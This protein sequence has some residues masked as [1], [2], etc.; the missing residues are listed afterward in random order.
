MAN[1]T[2]GAK[3]GI[4]LPK[5]GGDGPL[6][7]EAEEKDL[8]Y[9]G[10]VKLKDIND[11]EKANYHERD[12][13]FLAAL[14]TELARRGVD[15]SHLAPPA[16]GARVPSS[17]GPT[18]RSAPAQRSAGNGVAIQRA[19]PAQGSQMVIGSFGD[20]AAASA[21]LAEAQR[22]YHLVA[23]TT[24]IGRL[25]EGC[26]VAISLVYV[27]PNGPEVYAI[28]GDNRNPKPDDTVGLDRV[29]LAKIGA[30]AGVTWIA[31]HRTDNGSH[32]HYCAWEA[33]AEFP[34]FDMTSSRVPGNVDIDTREDGDI[35]GAAAAEIRKKARKRQ[36]NFDDGDGQLLEL[37]K[38]IV[39][40]CES[41]AMNKAIA[42][43]GVRRSYK[44]ED[45]KKAFAVAKLVFTGHS[46]DP[47]ARADFR[48]MIGARFLGASNA[49]YGAAPIMQIAAPQPAAYLA[50][51]AHAYAPPPVLH[52]PPPLTASTHGV[53]DDP[54]G[55]EDEED[56]PYADPPEKGQPAASTS[57]PE[58]KV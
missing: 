58:M 36:N 20:G 10:G 14:R 32:P 57:Q 19:A 11:P 47:E 28:T 7:E 37:R 16:A 41:K 4:R 44:R 8:L 45:L 13:Q 29:A 50:P 15:A 51:P 2:P 48:K 22:Q 1:T 30:A 46:D 56:Q 34:N 31:S 39:R 12:R 9:W 27:D 25:P 26:E 21:A 40:H 24:V 42:G 23:P 52:A 55:H 5:K 6:L 33:V 49:L 53:V 18:Q 17:S 54:Y 38:F 3:T 43:R 35:S